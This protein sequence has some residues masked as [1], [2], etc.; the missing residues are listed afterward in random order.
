MTLDWKNGKDFALANGI[1]EVKIFGKIEYDGEAYDEVTFK[2]FPN[3]Y[4]EDMTFNECV[5]EDCGEVALY[6][7]EM[8]NC[9]FKNVSNTEGHYTDFIGC[10]FENC[11]GYSSVLLTEGDSEVEGCIFYRC[12]ARG[13]DGY[14]IDQFFDNKGQILEIKKCRFINCTVENEEQKI[15]HCEY[16]SGLAKKK[17]IAIDNFDYET[18]KEETAFEDINA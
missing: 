12:S 5:F 17:L 4:L 13:E 14:I 8:A 1:S 16:L 18:C 2:N 15:A 10:K 7:C 3:I 9:T 11:V 6:G